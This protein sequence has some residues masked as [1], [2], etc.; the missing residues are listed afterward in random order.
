MLH[1]GKRFDTIMA[2]ITLPICE[3]LYITASSEEVCVVT[4]K[5]HA[6]MHV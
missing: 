4:D 6:L 5:A 1:Y 3:N 2:V